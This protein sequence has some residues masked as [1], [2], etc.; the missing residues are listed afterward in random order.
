MACVT[1]GGAR[2]TGEIE[3]LARE[4]GVSSVAT[5]VRTDLRKLILLKRVGTTAGGR[6]KATSV[7]TQSSATSWQVSYSSLMLV[8]LY[9]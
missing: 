7:S 1:C 4:G 2:W 5:L 8:V 6:M 9:S 3:R